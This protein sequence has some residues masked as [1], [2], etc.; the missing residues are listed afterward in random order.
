MRII[1]NGECYVQKEDLE[2]IISNEKSIPSSI[3]RE[4]RNAIVDDLSFIKIE[5]K[6]ALECVLNSNILDFEELNNKPLSTLEAFEYKI[7]A[8]IL[9]S[10]E[11]TNQM[12]KDELEALELE[13]KNREYILNQIR[14]I[15]EYKK[16]KSKIVYPSVPNPCVDGIDNGIMS[17]NISLNFSE[18]VIYNLDGSLIKDEDREFFET[19]Y[20]LLMHDYLPYDEELN[21]VTNVNGRYITLNNIKRPTYKRKLR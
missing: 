15:V 6:E 18:V 7:K 4:L 8:A 21:L 11:D 2:Y 16:R 9:D 1:S 13:R 5:D 20:R 10:C 12:S 14:Q 3:Y 19:S 17:A